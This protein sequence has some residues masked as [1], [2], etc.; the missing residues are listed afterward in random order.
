MILQKNA[1]L[2]FFF[3]LNINLNYL[4][5]LRCHRHNSSQ[6]VGGGPFWS[7]RYDALSAEESQ[8]DQH[9][10]PEGPL[11]HQKTLCL[12]PE[13]G[14]YVEAGLGW[15]DQIQQRHLIHVLIF[16]WA[17]CKVTHA[18]CNGLF[19]KRGKTWKKYQWVIAS[20]DVSS[21]SF[22]NKLDICSRFT[23]RMF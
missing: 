7:Q 11:L 15:V 12:H 4:H 23:V 8:P 16:C 17:H 18:T 19:W 3:F 13:L 14:I 20:E 5:L 1:A 10:H 6:R 21:L 2:P 9:A 22:P